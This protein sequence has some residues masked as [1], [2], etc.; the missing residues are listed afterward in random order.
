MCG[1]VV[2]GGVLCCVSLRRDATWR[3]VARR[4]LARRVATRCDALTCV[5]AHALQRNVLR[6]AWHNATKCCD[7]WRRCVAVR[8]DALGHDVDIR[9][10]RRGAAL[11]YDALRRGVVWRGVLSRVLYRR[12][13]SRGGV[14]CSGAVRC[15]V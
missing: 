7:A 2:R 6:I 8:L 1:G 15:A 5:D 14:V 10:A 9:H 4:G 12:S 3:G 13:V 11:R